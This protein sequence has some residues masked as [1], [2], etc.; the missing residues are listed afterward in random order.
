MAW[1]MIL[2][3]VIV[4]LV[5]LGIFLSSR[6]TYSPAFVATYRRTLERTG[7][8]EEALRE[9][10][11]LFT[12]RTPFNR[13][14]VHDIELI[15]QIFAPMPDPRPVAELFHEVDKRQDIAMLK[16]PEQLERY[17]DFV[18]RRHGW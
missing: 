2:G 7:S 10:I 3:I 8:K 12:R 11:S 9:S 5:G 4:V 17:A 14:S 13:L 15:V 18:R 16:D 6:M 1:W